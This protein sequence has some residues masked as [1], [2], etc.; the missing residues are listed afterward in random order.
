R[1]R[2]PRSV[3]PLLA[4]LHPLAES[5]S[6]RRW[7]GVD[8]RSILSIHRS[9]ASGRRSGFRV[10][11]AAWLGPSPGEGAPMFATHRFGKNWLGRAAG[12]SS[13]PRPARGRWRRTWNVEMLEG[14]T[15]LSTW[16]VNSLGDA[17]TGQGHA[18]TTDAMMNSSDVTPGVPTLMGVSV[19]QYVQA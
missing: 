13:A 6:S 10:G 3:D 16:T 17:G 1:D 5:A 14:R 7:N 15:L 9:S 18:G 19:P 12:H 11:S 8:A 2:G 4:H